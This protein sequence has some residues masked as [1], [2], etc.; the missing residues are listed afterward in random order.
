MEEQACLIWEGF[1]PI[2]RRNRTD[3]DHLLTGLS[4]ADWDRQ[5]PAVGWSIRDQVSH[6]GT[7]DR[8]ATMAAGEPARF[9]AEIL[10]QDRRERT[11]RQRETGRDAWPGL[12][13]LVA[14]WTTRHAGGVSTARSEDTHPL[15]WSGHDAALLC[16]P[17]H[18]NLGAR[19]GHCRH[20]G[21]QRQATERLQHVA[22]IGVRARPFSY[23]VRGLTPP[24]EEV[25]VELRSPAGTVWTWV[26]PRRRM[27]SSARPWTSAS[28]SPND[29][30]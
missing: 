30:I 8:V 19:T 2:C 11:A 17:P 3:L 29:A 14:Y 4:E 13:S 10:H 12:V 7:T 22:H 1:V 27:P 23:T 21:V 20:P 28:L 26:R 9:T 24:A 15:V 5:T 16:R 6:L 25:R 18:G